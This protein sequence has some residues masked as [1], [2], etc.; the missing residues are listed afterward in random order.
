MYLNDPH[1]LININAKDGLQTGGM[2]NDLEYYKDITY[3][4]KN[5]G[6]FLLKNNT[7]IQHLDK[8]KRLGSNK[9]LDID[10]DSRGNIWL[11]T[12]NGLSSV[13]NNKIKNYFKADG[14]P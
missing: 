4:G 2:V 12:T 8:A 7:I 9:I 11:A 3:I 14:L 10:I 13:K 5:N 1:T 6:L